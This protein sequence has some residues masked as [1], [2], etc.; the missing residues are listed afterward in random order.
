MYS[1]QSDQAYLSKNPLIFLPGTGRQICQLP[2]AGILQAVP[3]AILHKDFEASNTLKCNFSRITKRNP[4]WN[5]GSWDSKFCPEKE[6]HSVLKYLI[7]QKVS[8]SMKNVFIMSWEHSTGHPCFLFTLQWPLKL[9]EQFVQLCLQATLCAAF[10]LV[11]HIL[12][13]RQYPHI[14]FDLWLLH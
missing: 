6:S 9:L 11:G 2:K 12:S 10:H 13:Y 14:V 7:Q 3:Y 1:L 8:S 5:T 4:V